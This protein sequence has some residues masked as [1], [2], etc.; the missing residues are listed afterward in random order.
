MTSEVVVMNRMGVALAADSAVTVEVGDGSKVRDSALKV[1]MLSK[2]RP[3]GVM[4]YNNSSLLGVPWETIIKLFRREF[5]TRRCA[6]LAEYGEAL[7]DYLERNSSLFPPELQDRYFE[8]ALETEFLRIEGEAWNEYAAARLYTM[9]DRR[10]DASDYDHAER[11]IERALEDWAGKEDASYFDDVS[12]ADVVCGNSV[13]IN[14][15]VQRVFAGW[16]VGEEGVQRLRKIA[17]HL[18]NKDHFIDELYSG[19]V[20]AGFGEIEYFP[21]VWPL[22]IG[23][24]YRGRLKVRREPLVKVSEESPSRIMSFAYGEMV[25]SFLNGV[26]AKVL[27]RFRDAKAYIREMPL[28]AL[29]AVPG[30]KE[31]QKEIAI[32]AVRQV[33]ESKATEFGELVLQ[34][35][36]ERVVE[37]ERAV[38]ALAVKE[39]AQVA[40]T[41]V[42]LGSFQKQMSQDRETVG[43]PV[44]VAVISKG[45]GFIWIDR[46][47]YF[48]KELN[49]HF[50]R[51]YYEEDSQ[52]QEDVLSRDEEEVRNDE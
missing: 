9:G 47:H 4:V 22:T 36:A 31:E 17:Q 25:E 52:K 8:Q 26:S 18:V 48:E 40:S 24:I 6:T 20:I 23:G 13:G 37:I 16:H 50:F 14:D 10:E 42:G 11:A 32:N 15:V 39:L 51:N 21:V 41:L 35:C 49:G 30:L 29:E 19:V 5:G 2:Y 12:G 43:G 46:K 3:V 28:R 33:S 1:F 7:I 38:E 34:E 45:D 27:K 44:D